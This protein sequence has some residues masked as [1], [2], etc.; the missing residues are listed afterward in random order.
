MAEFEPIPYRI[1]I[2]VTGHRKLSDPAVLQ[3][4]LKRAIG[5]EI[6]KL[7]PAGSRGRT[8]NAFGLPEQP[9]FRSVSLVRWP[10]GRTAWLRVRFLSIRRH[11]S[12]LCY[13]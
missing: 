10:K 5:A 1:R 13:P 4:T 2:G 11:G 6:E 8:S 3:A 9:R 12:M 7:F